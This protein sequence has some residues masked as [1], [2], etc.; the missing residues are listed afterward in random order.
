[1]KITGSLQI[2]PLEIGLDAKDLGVPIA[3]LADIVGAEVDLSEPAKLILV[4]HFLPHR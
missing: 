2:S 1:V 4:G 3:H